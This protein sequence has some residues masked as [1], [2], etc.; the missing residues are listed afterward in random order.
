MKRNIRKFVSLLIVLVML[1]STFQLTVISAQAYGSISY[2]LNSDGASYCVA[3]CD[4]NYFG[5]AKISAT[6]SGLPVTKIAAKAFDNSDIY[7]VVIPDSVTVIGENAFSGCD[8]LK[9]VTFGSGVTK[10]QKY[11][12]SD[13]TRLSSITLPESVKFIEDYAFT[14]CTSL[15]QIYVLSSDV[16]ISVYSDLG[17]VDGAVISGNIHSTA[18]KYAVNSGIRFLSIVC[19]EVNITKTVSSASGMVISWDKVDGASY[20]QVYKKLTDAD[21]WTLISDKVKKTSFVDSD[22]V[23][24]K[25]YIYTVR[26]FNE[27]ADGE[28]NT[29]GSD[30]MYLSTPELVSVVSSEKGVTVKWKAVQGAETYNIYC[31]TR[32]GK[33]QLVGNSATLSFVDRTAKK[34]REYFYT[35]TAVANVYRKTIESAYNSSGIKVRVN[36]VAKPNIVKIDMTDYNQITLEWTANKGADS[37]IVYRS[38]SENGTYENVAKVKTNTWTD[39]DLT[40]NKKYY[41]KVVTVDGKQS[42][43]SSVKSRTSRIPAPVISTNLY[44]KADSITITWNKVATASGYTVYRLNN[45]NKWVQIAT[46]RGNDNL[47]Y[48]DSVSGKH[49]YKVCSFITVNSKEYASAASE[50]VTAT[51]FNKTSLSVEQYKNAF[52]DVVTWQPVANATGYLLYYK[53]GKTGTWTRAVTLNERFT[54]YVM[55]VN[56]GEYYYWRVRPIFEN[57]GHV[58]AGPYSNTADVM[59][60]YT[61]TVRVAVSSST[62][63]NAETVT[64]NIANKGVCDFKVLSVDAY[65]YNG[66]DKP[67]NNGKITLV[68]SA[69][70]PINEQIIPAGSSANVTFLVDGPKN[71]YYDKN[72]IIQLYFT[73]DNIKYV[74]Q[75][76]A[77]LE[78]SNARFIR[79]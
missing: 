38:E 43:E 13:C 22:V 55:D 35:V 19:D 6:Y 39:K 53:V 17:E 21:S 40:F 47:S 5:R 33:W 18:E 15:K 75:T 2:T 49:Q 31:K 50:T 69:K 62:V 42:A 66:A 73:Y 30:T 51:T 11:A 71:G 7:A 23:S 61:P 58:I 70:Q 65:I 77:K 27:Y 26:A 44:T 54:S 56:H 25:K 64:V 34:G 28:D 12:F 10:I 3:D 16:D 52:A 60:F 24:G 59:I 46:I 78:G 45:Q 67:D 79:A 68:N 72:T 37:Y 14:G 20:Y 74:M 29:I 8:K 41:Y 63:P 1:F 36:Y 32:F 9:T 57:N 48:T 76:D 4:D